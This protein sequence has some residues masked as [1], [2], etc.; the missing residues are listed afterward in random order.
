LRNNAAY[1]AG[2]MDGEGSFF[3]LETGKKH[4]RFSPLISIGMTHQQTVKFAADI[5]RVG[6]LVKVARNRPRKDMFTIR[7]TT[8]KEIKQI[9]QELSKH[10]KTKLDQ[11]MLLLE[12]F[13]LKE[14]QTTAADSNDISKENEISQKMVDG[15]L[16]LKSANERGPPPDYDGIRE[17][18]LNKIS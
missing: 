18:L 3:L 10:S 16:K 9:C 2:L 4:L 5:F 12:Y 13:S 17:K 1:L 7:I 8:E 6:P 15:Y 11:I 14:M